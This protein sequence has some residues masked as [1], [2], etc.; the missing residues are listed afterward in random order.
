[1]SIDKTLSILF[2]QAPR[3][4]IEKLKKYLLPEEE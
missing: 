2:S 1:M 3:E 4:R